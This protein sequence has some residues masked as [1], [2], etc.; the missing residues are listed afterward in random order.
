M[1]AHRAR[2]GAFGPSDCI[3]D[4]VREL[5]VSAPFIVVRNRADREGWVRSP[6]CGPCGSQPIG[7]RCCRRPLLSAAV[8][9]QGPKR[10]SETMAIFFSEGSLDLGP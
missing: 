6:S 4:C 7:P 5:F 10:K 9:G 1:R 8:Q 2:N 3:A